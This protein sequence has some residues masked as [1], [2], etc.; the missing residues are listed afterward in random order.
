LDAN[1]I[2]PAPAVAKRQ[3]LDSID[4]LRG[5]VMIIMALDH[6]RDFYSSKAFSEFGDPTDLDNTTLGIF[7]T[8]WITHYCAPTF[9]FLAGTGA[10]LSGTRG[11]S[12]PELSWF[13]FTRGLW[14]AFFE[15]TINTAMWSFD[16]DLQH[17]G[18][19]VFWAIGWSM[20]VLSVLVYLQ[21]W[22]VTLFGLAM[23]ASHNLLDGLTAEQVHLPGWL[24]MVLHSPPKDPVPVVGSITFV[25]GYSLVPWMGVM[26][27]GYG[28]G[29]LY[30]LD[31]AAR[32]TWLFILGLGLI[33]LFV[34]IRMQNHGYV[35]EKPAANP[36]SIVYH[37][38][39]GYGDARAWEQR[40]DPHVP[41]EDKQPDPRWTAC[42]FLN[43]TKYPPSLLYLLMTLGPSILFLAIFDRPLGQIAQPIITIGRVPFFFYLLHIP[44][45]HGS[46]VLLDFVRF[47]K[48]PLANSGPWMPWQSL[49]QNYGVSLPVVYLIWAA[50]IVILYF[51]CR[52][53]AG[54]KARYRSAWLS[55]F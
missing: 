37:E 20:V 16:Y 36:P 27:A 18:A 17:Y 5:V 31:R 12:K 33:A 14:L 8:R 52:W 39:H 24:W 15:V 1:A 43:C 4:L 26:A 7:F 29:S 47:G 11:K 35:D 13:L 21:T 34:G 48:S 6:V 28:F 44:L 55:Y 9:I 38:P 10:F 46:A 51:P 42:S 30:L 19:G 49:P 22:A 53:Y 41:D 45:I 3:R 2:P 32:R 40:P 50:V 25:T 54:V 23:I